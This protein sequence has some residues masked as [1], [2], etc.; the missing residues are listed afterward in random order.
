MKI[1][2]TTYLKLYKCGEY[3]SEIRATILEVNTL[4]LRSF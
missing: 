4:L 2:S 1:C 3:C